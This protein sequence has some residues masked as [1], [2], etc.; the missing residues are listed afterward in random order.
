MPLTDQERIA[1]DR[2]QPRILSLWRA[3]QQ[4]RNVLSFM[5]T[6]AHPDDETTAMLAAL[7]MRDGLSLSYA[8]ANRGEG[9]QNDIGTE[10][11]EALGILRTAEM[12]R[13]CDVLSMRLYWLSEHMDDTIFDFGFSKSGK[14]T[15]G[16]WGRDRTLR[17]MV[18]ILRTERPDIMCTTFLDVP[19][20]H[21][22]H[23]AMTQTAL[24]AFEAAA[25]PAFLPD[26][27]DPWSVSRIFLPAWSGAGGS[28][29]DEVPPP[30]A[31][32]VVSA[33]GFDPV[34]GWDWARIGQQSRAFHRTQGMGRWIPPSHQQADWPLHCAASRA[35]GTAL[36]EGLPEVF[37]D[38]GGPAALDSALHELISGFPDFDAVLAAACNACQIARTARANLSDGN[39]M[40]HGHRFDRAEQALCT[41]IRLAAGAQA[42]ARCSAD[43]LIAGQDADIAVDASTRAGTLATRLLAPAS[44]SATATSLQPGADAALTD[45]YPA[46]YDPLAPHLPAL[47]VTLDIDGHRYPSVVPMEVTPQLGPA[48][49]ATL[50]PRTAVINTQTDKTI[51]DV[52]ISA[53]TPVG[54]APRLGHATGITPTPTDSGFRVAIPTDAPDGLLELPLTIDSQPAMTEHRIEYDHVAPRAFVR[55][56]SLALRVLSVA[57]AFD[58]TIGYIGA[59]NDRVSYW[60]RALGFAC[61]NISDRDMA[62]PGWAARFDTIVIGIFALRFRPGLTT[63][64]PAL[65]R[66]VSG[67][68]HLVTLYHRP[69]D[70]W[71]PQTTAPS[72]LEIGQPSLRWRVT[73]EAA[74]IT[75]LEP[76]HPILKG[77]NPIGPDDW[78]GWHKERGLYFAKSWDDAYVPLLEMADPEEIPHKGALLSGTFGRG[79]HTHCAL[80]LHHQ[81]EKLVSGAFRLM[82]NIVSV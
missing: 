20:Q 41:V 64:L 76:D 2:T 73:D 26:G 42:E 25:D 59:G 16:K 34:S 30:P 81:M 46:Y 5:Q 48:F 57:G 72:R 82:A 3:L 61:H 35:P 14:E 56:A 80:I 21:G 32:T 29:D 38:I 67:G 8:C 12:E 10:A 62:T 1:R 79:R 49:K 78:A 70:N 60:L 11:T 71:D 27:P 66:W 9:G 44:W 19:G 55:P 45:P 22:H 68:G 18:E 39:K 63:Q 4:L 50:T 65:H 77:P 52:A 6:G 7:C 15:L 36:T 69:W 74:T 54:C 53:V 43:W 13:A 17:R 24:D 75:H 37:A 51:L 40:R 33:H 58:R 47:E 28:Y 31:T 23:R